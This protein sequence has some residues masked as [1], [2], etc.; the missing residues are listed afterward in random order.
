[1]KKTEELLEKCENGETRS[2]LK[3]KIELMKTK[4]NDGVCVIAAAHEIAE[5]IDSYF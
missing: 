5:K 3:R 2:Q 4:I 1:V